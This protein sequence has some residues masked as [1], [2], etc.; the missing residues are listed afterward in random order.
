[1]KK[2]AVATLLFCVVLFPFSPALAKKANKIISPGDPFPAVSS[3]F[4]F[5]PQD[6]SYLGL[7]NKFFWEKNDFSIKN[8]IADIIIVEFFNKYCTS[9]QTQAPVLNEVYERITSQHAVA[10]KVKFIGIGAGNNAKEVERFRF[11][12]DV[13][14]PLMPDPSFSFYEAIGTPG[15]TPFTIILKK[16]GSEFIVA[17]VHM[18]LTREPDLLVQAIKAAAEKDIKQLVHESHGWSVSNADDR[19]LDLKLPQNTVIEK[20]KKSMLSACNQCTEIKKFSSMMTS[21]GE[22]IY[23]GE[24][25]AEGKTLVVFSEVFIIKPV[26]DVCHGIHFIITFDTKGTIVEFTPIHLTKIGNVAWNADDN[27][28]IRRKLVGLSIKKGY[29]FNSDVDAVSMATMSSSLIFSCINSLRD[30]VKE[31]EQNG[32]MQ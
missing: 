5:L 24:L 20:V 29:T 25:A 15:G 27:E 9:C 22:S 11:E 30:V 26:C 18:G 14:F 10:A 12:K 28:F 1:M 13:P 2:Y 23:R 16:I 32:N 19:M 3:D 17:S 6:R 4:D 7:S 21:A 31:L 8:I